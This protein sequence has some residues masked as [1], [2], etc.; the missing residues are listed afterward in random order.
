MA[1]P[2][3]ANQVFDRLVGLE[4]WRA[5]AAAK[6]YDDAKVSALI[7]AWVR[8][9]ERETTFRVNPVQIVTGPDG[10]YD[11]GTPGVGVVTVSGTDVTQVIGIGTAF[12]TSVVAGNW[13][14]VGALA[15]E[16]AAVADNTHLTLRVEEGAP[17]PTFTSA[18]YSVLPTEVVVEA[19]YDY[20]RANADEYFVTT[21]RERPVRSVQRFRLMYNAKVLIY[22]VPPDWFSLDLRSARFWMLPY[23]GSQVVAGAAALTGYGVLLSEHVPNIL[24]FDYQAGLPDN[25]QNSREWADIKILLSEFCALQY[26]LDTAYALGAGQD[27]QSVSING[28]NQTFEFDRFVTRKKELMDNVE[29]F[30]ATL[31]EQQTPLMLGMV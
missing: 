19:G 7:P 13:L 21:F 27:R 2:V 20:Y 17:P 15:Y 26:L 31:R 3:T 11:A 12:L 22:Q 25:W 16:V 23:Y 1:D 9:F 24:F 8:R 14:K 4:R 18:A 6:G 29:K 5:A 28:L 10:T 30:A